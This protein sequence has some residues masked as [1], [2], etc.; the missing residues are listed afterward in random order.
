MQMGEKGLY[1]Y[2]LLNLAILHADFGC[3]SEANSALQEAIA[4]AREN[5]DLPCLNYSLSWFQQFW[6]TRPQESTDIHKKGGLGSEKEALSFLKT[7]A[8]ESNMWTLLSTTLLS[9]AKLL[10]SKV[11]SCHILSFRSWLTSIIPRERAWHMPSKMS[12]R[13]LTLTS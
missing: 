10:L 9:E 5:H 12:S 2:A 8:K 7:K 6:R 1:Q 13:R 4:T 3:V 11:F